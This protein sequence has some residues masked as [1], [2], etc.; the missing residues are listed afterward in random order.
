MAKAWNVSQLMVG[1]MLVSVPP[2]YFP[3]QITTPHG[4]T[5][6]A[7]H[8]LSHTSHMYKLPAD[9]CIPPERVSHYVA[10]QPIGTIL[11]MLRKVPNLL[12]KTVL[13]QGQGQ[14]GMMRASDTIVCRLA[15][16]ISFRV[17]SNARACMSVGT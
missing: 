2:G 8:F 1:I 6:L 11:W 9:S 14:N 5:G 16:T 17:A 4:H 15:A 12:H 7:R 13:V 3:K 10:A